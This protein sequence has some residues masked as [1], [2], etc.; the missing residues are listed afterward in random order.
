MGL[1]NLDTAIRINADLPTKTDVDVKGHNGK[2]T[3]YTLLSIPFYL[4][5]QIHRL[6]AEEW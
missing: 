4:T 6:L 3:R 2:N 5:G 1:K